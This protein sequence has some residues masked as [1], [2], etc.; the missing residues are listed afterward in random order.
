[1][2]GSAFPTTNNMNLISCKIYIYSYLNDTNIESELW[3]HILI[4]YVLTVGYKREKY[5]MQTH[6]GPNTHFFHAVF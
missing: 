4:E 2:N 3:E 6:R 5:A 1:M